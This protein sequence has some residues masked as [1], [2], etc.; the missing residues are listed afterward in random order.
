MAKIYTSAQDETLIETILHKGLRAKVPKWTVL[1]LAL[2]KS[3][4]LTTPPEVLPRDGGKGGEY[5][6]EQLT[7]LGQG[8][9][10]DY[11]EAIR[12]LLSV[13]HDENLFEAEERFRELLEAH[14]RRGLREF[15]TGWRDSHDFHEYL[16]QELFGG[17]SAGGAAP[18]NEEAVLRALREIGVQ[19]D[20][21]GS[22]D[23]VRLTRYLLRLADVHH[24]DRL[25][26]GAEKLA[27]SLGLGEQAVYVTATDEPK[28]L[29]L[30]I[31][32]PAQTWQ[33]YDGQALRAWLTQAPSQ[34]ALPVYPGVDVM[35]E[36]Y[37]FDLAAAPHLL[38]GGATGSGKSV[39]MHALI[40]SI[41]ITRT[42]AQ[43]RLL[44]IDPK[45]VEFGVYGASAHLLPGSH[46]LTQPD[47]TLEALQ[48]LVAT[49]EVRHQQFA[50]SAVRDIDEARDRGLNLHRIVVFVEELADLILRAPAVEE[51]LVR[52]A[53]KARSAG[54][55]L[56]L[57]TQRPDAQTFSGLLRS[58]VPARI[59]LTVQKSSESKII[60]DDTGAEQLTGRGDMLVKLPGGP[61]M[62]VHGVML[63]RDDAIFACR[64]GKEAT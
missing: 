19:A 27:F 11:T 64:Q 44:L 6:F 52:L 57:A 63:T 4:S 5:A 16:L 1:R 42:P 21:L 60:L 53:Q 59:A 29:A 9:R 41:L 45:A 12:A 33:R 18:P 2:A 8:E 49:M 30:D 13:Y 24:L 58:N 43:V 62:R 35:G 15:R 22:K 17:E 7:G 47:E 3:L 31:P 34:W 61:P 37:G 51:A 56:V 26:R 36:P 39:C 14:V 32:R 46:I 54:I 20:I 23:G 50:E 55:H 10:A 25:K 38:V 28:T 40:Q 48:G